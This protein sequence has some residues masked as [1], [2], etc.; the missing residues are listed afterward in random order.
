MNASLP[1]VSLVERESQEE[2]GS[3]EVET[4]SEPVSGTSWNFP[5]QEVK[6]DSQVNWR[7]NIEKKK[8]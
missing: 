4:P 7:K 6:Q 2:G 5:S 3:Q 1:K 8:N